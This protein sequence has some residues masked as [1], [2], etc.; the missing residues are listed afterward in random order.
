[1]FNNIASKIKTLAVVCTFIGITLSFVY[2][3]M[4]INISAATGLLTII[5]GSLFSWIGSFILYGFGEIIEKVTEIEKNTKKGI[6]I[7]IENKDI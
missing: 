1:M 2:G 6:K 5:I 3:L 4:L 7:D